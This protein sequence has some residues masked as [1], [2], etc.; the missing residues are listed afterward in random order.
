M[1]HQVISLQQDLSS[2][3]LTEP[4]VDLPPL[5]WAQGLAKWHMNDKVQPMA[6]RGFKSVVIV[7]PAFT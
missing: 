2:K 3:S 6:A 5:P 1:T 4:C 7:V